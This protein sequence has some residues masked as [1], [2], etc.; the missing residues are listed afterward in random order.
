MR[1]GGEGEG[2]RGLGHNLSALKSQR[3]RSFCS[4]LMQA[5]S[6]SR[7][8]GQELQEVEGYADNVGQMDGMRA[9]Q[10]SSSLETTISKSL[11]IRYFHA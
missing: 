11:N 7:G 8:K 10:E 6:S 9:W 4:S 1:R 5:L 2:G 3:G